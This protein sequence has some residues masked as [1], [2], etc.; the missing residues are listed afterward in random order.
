MRLHGAAATPRRR[1]ASGTPPRA[2]RP[3]V[4][5]ARRQYG[6]SEASPV[7]HTRRESA[8]EYVADPALCFMFSSLSYCIMDSRTPGRS[9][10]LLPGHTPPRE[11]PA[12]HSHHN[13][14]SST[15]NPANSDIPIRNPRNATNSNPIKVICYPECANNVGTVDPSG[16]VTPTGQADGRSTPS[17]LSSTYAAALGMYDHSRLAGVPAFTAP[18]CDHAWTIAL[19]RP[20]GIP[21]AWAQASHADSRLIVHMSLAGLRAARPQ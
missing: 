20:T 19:S 1:G 15:Q 9:R 11:P 7:S 6:R 12:P 21:L 13:G 17:S 10:V 4:R 2:R 5:S 18:G 3:A 14:S 8:R 16:F